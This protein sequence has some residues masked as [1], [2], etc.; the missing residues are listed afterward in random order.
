MRLE[1][2]QRKREKTYKLLTMGDYGWSMDFDTPQGIDA[3]EYGRVLEYPKKR[4][5]ISDH[6][7]ARSLQIN[8][9]RIGK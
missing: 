5:K 1:S 6:E 2:K 4:N 9:V 3:V 7:K 8:R